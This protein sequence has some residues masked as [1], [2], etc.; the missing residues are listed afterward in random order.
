LF[1]ILIFQEIFDKSILSYSF[2]SIYF[3][4]VQLLF[5]IMLLIWKTGQEHGK[6]KKRMMHCRF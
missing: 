5:M 4:A 2:T 3:E 6:N 1:Q